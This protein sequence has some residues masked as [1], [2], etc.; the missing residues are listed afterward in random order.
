MAMNVEIMVLWVLRLRSLVGG[1]QHF[2]G[3][4]YIHHWDQMMAEFARFFR[5]DHMGG[6]HFELWEGGGDKT[7]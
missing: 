2:K 7:A 5:Q 6:G 1:H 3:A 4:S